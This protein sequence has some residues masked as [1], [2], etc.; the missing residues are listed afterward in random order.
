MADAA[1]N[2]QIILDAQSSHC[3]QILY[4]VSIFPDL[5]EKQISEHTTLQYYLRNK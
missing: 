4:N 3:G 2:P 1:V 5:Q